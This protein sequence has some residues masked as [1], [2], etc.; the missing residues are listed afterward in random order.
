MADKANQTPI[1]S[2]REAKK[3]LLENKAVLLGVIVIVQALVAIGLTQFV[4]VPK[5]AVHQAGIEGG[6]MADLDEEAAR[7]SEVVTVIRSVAD[8]TNLLALN[9]T[10]E[11]ARA[12]EAGKGFAVVANE[13]KELARQTAAATTEIKEQIDGQRL[14]FC[15]DS[16]VR[17]T[18]LKDTISRLFDYGA[19]EV[20]MRPACPCLIYPCEFLNFSTSSK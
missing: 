3:G 5:L 2:E 9:A 13:I 16:I 14:L 12:G 19:K 17:G 11:A 4:L 20:H 6:S 15:E 18:Q 8:Q 7:I 1:D 10:I